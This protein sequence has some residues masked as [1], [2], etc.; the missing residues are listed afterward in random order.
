MIASE[1]FVRKFVLAIIRDIRS[2]NLSYEEKNTIYTDLVPHVSERA[3]QTSLKEK[4]VSPGKP[5][6]NALPMPRRDMKKLVAPLRKP[7]AVRTSFQSPIRTYSP[8][9]TIPI[10]MS[11]SYSSPPV[12]F[13]GGSESTDISQDYGKITPLLRD[14]QISL[15]ECSGAGKPL[16]I[17]RTGQRQITRITL[18][19]QE[20]KNILE[21]ISDAAHIPL[22]EGIFR[23][24]VDNFSIS[25]VISEMIGSRFVI[26]KQTAYTMLER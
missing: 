22:L 5:V 25:A 17:V 3:M 6:T 14:P 7:V 11:P 20:I 10:Q 4:I 8:S 19:R 24:A 1:P 9:P 26:R 13:S 16:R 21:K 23:A 18:S 12:P 2:H 15:I